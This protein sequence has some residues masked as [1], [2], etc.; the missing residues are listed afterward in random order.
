MALILLIDTSGAQ[1]IV[2]LSANGVVLTAQ[3]LPDSRRQAAL[4]QP[5][6]AEVVAAAGK[7]INDLEA[8]SVVSGPGSY[9]GLRVGLASAKGL[10][11]A[12]NIPL[13]M[14]DRLL[15]MALSCNLEIQEQIVWVLLPARTGEW[16]AGCYRGN[17]AIDN[18]RH[19]EEESLKDAI[20][21]SGAKNICLPIGVIETEFQVLFNIPNISLINV[22]L[23]VA[24]F[25]KETER[26]YVNK[27][28]ENLSLS[29]PLYLKSAFVTSPNAKNS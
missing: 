16:F 29:T 25:S 9:T 5:V 21:E 10:C 2:A 7:E 1:G 17:A 15:L 18:P 24:I 6:I 3:T 8:I 19:W 20:L 14:P 13:L 4:L 27:V 28:V 26:R 23:D 12:L 22:D 11:F